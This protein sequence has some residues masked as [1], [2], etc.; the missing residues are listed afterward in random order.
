MKRFFCVVLLVL[1]LGCPVSH[2]TP[3]PDVVPEPEP[4]S[5]M[6]ELVSEVE[7]YSVPEL[8]PF[9]TEFANIIQNDSTVIKTTGQIREAHIRALLLAFQKTDMASR[10]EGLGDKVNAA[11]AKS[12]G[13]KDVELTPELRDRAVETF[14][15]LS[16]AVK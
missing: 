1:A 11:L 12:L 13:M 10:T 4:V 14:K 5:E 3:Q 8:V 6:Q 15:A 9:Y 16:H 7:P 2:P